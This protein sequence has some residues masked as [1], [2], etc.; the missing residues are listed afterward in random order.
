MT[1]LPAGATAVAE[2][3]IPILTTPDRI[4]AYN[5]ALS[6]KEIAQEL[7]KNVYTIYRWVKAGKIPCHRIEREIHFEPRIL[8]KWLEAKYSRLAGVFA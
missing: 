8:A 3:S 4:R 6:V 1:S 2:T 5:R 7:D